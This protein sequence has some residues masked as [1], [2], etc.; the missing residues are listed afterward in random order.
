MLFSLHLII[1]V[2]PIDFGPTDSVLDFQVKN[3]GT[4]PGQESLDFVRHRQRLNAVFL[5]GHAET[6][7]MDDGGLSRISVANGFSD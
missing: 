7:L 4:D 5:D 1:S 6:F 3:R 2:G